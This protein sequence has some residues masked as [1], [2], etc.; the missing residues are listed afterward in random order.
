MEGPPAALLGSSAML[1]SPLRSG[2][3]SSLEVS[4]SDIGSQDDKRWVL[5]LLRIKHL[6]FGTLITLSLKSG[7]TSFKINKLPG[8]HEKPHTWLLGC[9]VDVTFTDRQLGGFF[10]C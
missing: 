8:P 1:M 9:Q 3:F 4:D 5:P 10:Q 6:H 2:D 7:A